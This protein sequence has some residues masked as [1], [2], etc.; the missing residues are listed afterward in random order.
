MIITAAC[1]CCIGFVKA[2]EAK[3]E[4][5]FTDN[6]LD[7]FKHIRNNI[8]YFNLPLDEIFNSYSPKHKIFGSFFEQIKV[9][10]W[11]DVIARKEYNYISAKT[12]RLI[13]EYGNELGKSDKDNQ[14]KLSGFYIDEL[15]EI[16]NELSQRVPQKMRVYISLGFYT[17]ILIIILF[18]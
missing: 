4:L 14:L 3:K 2:R 12:F 6:L 9:C 13:A 1:A 7:L 17:G 18:I 10:G 16:Y 15:T 11:S 5:I 8:E